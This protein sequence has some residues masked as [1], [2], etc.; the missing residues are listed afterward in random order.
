MW[1]NVQRIKDDN[2]AFIKTRIPKPKST[3]EEAF[4]LQIRALKLPTP[5]R[6]YVFAPP[7]KYRFDYAWPDI[8]MAVEIDGGI[9][10]KGRHTRGKGFEADCLKIALAIQNGWRVY[11]FSTGQVNKMVA[12]DFIE[13]E[14]SLLSFERTK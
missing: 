2:M 9:W 12:I 14:F 8:K 1:R 13:K 5:V 10:T 3:G 6:E 7:R 4:A 11:R